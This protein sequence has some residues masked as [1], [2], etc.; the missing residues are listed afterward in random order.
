MRATIYYFH[1]ALAVGAREPA[2]AQCFNSPS[3][4]SQQH[5]EAPHT[6]KSVRISVI[7][8]S[9]QKN[10]INTPHRLCRRSTHNT[11][12]SLLIML[13]FILI[14]SG[15]HARPVYLVAYRYDRDARCRHFLGFTLSDDFDS[16]LPSITAILFISLRLL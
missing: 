7:L 4:F 8:T 11:P 10:D 6:H 3:S 1:E 2:P 5:F 14:V 12:Y 9:H 16:Q 15:T 13:I